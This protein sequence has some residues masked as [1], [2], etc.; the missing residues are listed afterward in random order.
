M[1]DERIIIRITPTPAVQDI[2]RKDLLRLSRIT[3][4][5]PEK[6]SRRISAGKSIAILTPM[7]PKLEDVANLLRGIGFFV[8]I[9]PAEGPKVSPP[10]S[11]NTFRRPRCRG[12]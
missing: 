4:L 5:P 7:H 1:A 2:S 9:S 12:E 10:S 3:R 11:A 8:T 6:V